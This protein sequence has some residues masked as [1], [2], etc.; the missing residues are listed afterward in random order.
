MLNIIKQHISGFVSL[1]YPEF[2]SACGTNL[3][4]T[5]K[6]ICGLC[7]NSLPKTNFHFHPDNLA[8]KLF[9]GKALIRSAASYYYYRKGSEV[10]SLIHQLKYKDQKDVG[11][12]VGKWYAQELKESSLFADVDT[13]MPVPLHPDKFKKRGYNQSEQIAVGM[14]QEFNARYD[15]QSLTRKYFTETQTRKKVFDRH[16]NVD[17]VF[18][19]ESNLEKPHHILIV[20]DVITTGSTLIACINAIRAKLGTDVDISVATIAIAGK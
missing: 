16:E 12:I 4:Q 20:D 6:A 3:Y 13:I 8:T 1:A 10:K 7:R 14:I 18:V 15:N 19:Y 2:C 9:W 11:E 17:D 5:E